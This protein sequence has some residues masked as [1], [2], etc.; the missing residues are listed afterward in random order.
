MIYFVGNFVR[1]IHL[2]C[3]ICLN[4]NDLMLSSRWQSI[5]HLKHDS[6]YDTDNFKEFCRHIFSD[7]PHSDI[8]LSLCYVHRNRKKK[9]F[10]I[11]WDINAHIKNSHKKSD[12]RENTRSGSWWASDVFQHFKKKGNKHSFSDFEEYI[13]LRYLKRRK[14]KSSFVKMILRD[15]LT[16][17]RSIKHVNYRFHI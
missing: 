14:K 12:N 10:K 2:A 9:G 17:S 6:I 3:E 4:K 7:R 8:S 13:K 1:S 11:I 5:T 16:V 15:T